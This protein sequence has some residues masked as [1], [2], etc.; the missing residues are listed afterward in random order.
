[1]K[2]NLV[3]SNVE[4]FIVNKDYLITS[5]P[6]KIIVYD[7][8]QLGIIGNISLN[9]YPEILSVNKNNFI[10]S[11]GAKSFIVDYSQNKQQLYELDY[12][13]MWA[14][15]FPGKR[16]VYIK[17]MT[18]QVEQN[19]SLI[20]YDFER[21]KEIWNTKC[22]NYGVFLITEDH[23]FLG[24]NKQ[25]V[26]EQFDVT[27]GH[28][29]WCINIKSLLSSFYPLDL[30]DC[31]ILNPFF[32]NSDTLIIQLIERKSK[33][34]YLLGINVNTGQLHWYKKAINNL[35][36]FEGWL[37]NLEPEGLFR[38]INP[39]N[40]D[41]EL[42]KD[43]YDEFKKVDIVCDG[44]F[45]VT[46]DTIYFKNGLQGKFAVLDLQT[47]KIKVTHKLPD[48]NSINIDDAPMPIEEKIYIKSSQNNLFVY[49]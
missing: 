29:S 19:F 46:N 49:E 11:E 24:D 44:R 22:S 38:K 2:G 42:Q 15:H 36:L 26:V 21:K 3:A 35:E 8:N 45:T 7:Q 43:L 28:Q 34:R 27:T 30:G 40:G 47:H 10:V 41:I 25:Q 48:K 6:G 1:M 18:S 16:H 4:S 23:I 32:V 39:K 31:R 13:D 14:V 17:K 9:N 12:A 20:K 5:S 33:F 37:Y